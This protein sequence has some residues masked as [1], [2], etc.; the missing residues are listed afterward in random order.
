MSSSFSTLSL[1]VNYARFLGSRDRVFVAGNS[2]GA[3]FQ[4]LFAESDSVEDSPFVERAHLSFPKEYLTSCELCAVSRLNRSFVAAATS[5]L[6]GSKSTLRLLQTETT[7]DTAE[8]LAHD[9]IT[10]SSSSS[11]TSLAFQRDLEFL[12]SANESGEVVV[13][14]VSVGK[15]VV[16]FAADPCGVTSVAFATSG[17]LVSIGQSNG[18]NTLKVWDIRALVTSGADSQDM[19]RPSLQLR[20]NTKKDISTKS[21]RS[22]PLGSYTSML[23][24]PLQEVVLCGSSE[25][26][27]SSWDLRVN[28]QVASHFQCHGDQG[29]L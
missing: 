20:H 18:G 26:V 19:A 6:A 11:I 17:Q 14:D 21:A 7:A 2:S 3:E 8:I 10:Y 29:N 25:G 23:A 12:A 1:P 15:E 5:D 13:W 22:T 9:F 24:H 4:I 16:R 27:I 28:N